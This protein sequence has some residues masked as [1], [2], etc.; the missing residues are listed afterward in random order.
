MTSEI[1]KLKSNLYQYKLTYEKK[2]E[3]LSKE[4]SELVLKTKSSTE[5]STFM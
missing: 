5:I 3:K 1:E 4:F 2:A